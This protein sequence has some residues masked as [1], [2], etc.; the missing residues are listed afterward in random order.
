MALARAPFLFEGPARSAVHALKFKGWREVAAALARAMVEVAPPGSDAVTWVPLSRR[1]LAER[2][3]DQARVLAE[4]VGRAISLPVLG[5][6]RRATDTAPQARRGGTDRR[7]AMEDAFR[8]AG[9]APSRVLLVD[10]VLTTGATAAA[11]TRALRGAGAREVLLLTAARAARGAL[12][13]RYTRDGL[14][15]G[16]VVAPGDVPPAVDASR[17]RNDPRKATVGR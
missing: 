15:P 8:S 5:L 1:R 17:G 10:D 7:A 9:T 11:C 4:A 12:P 13:A 14:T 16:S 3:F 2:G 6:A